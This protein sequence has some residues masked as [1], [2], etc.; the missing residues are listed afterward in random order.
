[1][2]EQQKMCYKIV[3]NP[4]YMLVNQDSSRIIKQDELKQKLRLQKALAKFNFYLIPLKTFSWKMDPK[5]AKE[6]G[7]DLELTPCV[8]CQKQ[9]KVFS[10]LLS[11]VL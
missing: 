7:E 2:I 3:G 10:I 9:T 5:E 6:S 11:H 8:V 1:M 4:D